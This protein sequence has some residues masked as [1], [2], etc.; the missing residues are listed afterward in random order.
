MEAAT[1]GYLGDSL[2]TRMFCEG[3]CSKGKGVHAFQVR[4][5]LHL[6]WHAHTRSFL[7]ENDMVPLVGLIYF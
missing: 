6:R 2:L 3:G 5:E 7:I 1:L 4:T